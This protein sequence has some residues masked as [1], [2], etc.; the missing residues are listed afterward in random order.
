MTPAPRAARATSVW[1]P[2][3]D[4]ESVEWLRALTGPEREAATERLHDHLLRI[5]RRELR[6]RGEQARI[7]GPELD[8]LAH[9]S[10][11][12]AL[13]SILA[14]L[15]E[16][17]GDSRFTTW[18]YRFV[19]LEVSNK[20]GRHFWTRPRAPFDRE[21]WE[22][23][24]DRFGFDPAQ[25]SEWRETIEALR[26][27]VEHELTPYQRTLFVAIVLNGVPVDA[28]TARLGT[29]RNAIYKALFDARRKLRASLVA[30]GLL[31]HHEDA[32]RERP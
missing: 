23:L 28:M 22:R 8:D 2:S 11:S 32:E 19:V 7:T 21:D 26:L 5:A 25:E 10:A 6:R 17:R 14:K 20:L 12:D 24:P 27:A 9:Q 4:P 3:L 1:F 31:D 13:V 15:E 18:A 30:R 16:F 29:N